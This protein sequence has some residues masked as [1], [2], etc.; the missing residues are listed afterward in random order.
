MSMKVV[1]AVTIVLL[2]LAGVVGLVAVASGP[3][4]RSIPISELAQL[5]K[6]GQISTIEVGGDGA[7]ATTRQ[8][9]TFGLHVEPSASLS[10]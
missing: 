5:V 4:T 9:D 6:Q 10:Q 3:H 1:L 8:Q 2:A 7:V